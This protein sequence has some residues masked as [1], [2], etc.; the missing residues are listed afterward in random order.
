MMIGPFA[1]GT[2]DAANDTTRR[3]F[4]KPPF[5]S[6]VTQIGS[7]EFN[8]QGAYFETADLVECPLGVALLRKPPR[9]L[10]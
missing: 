4:D 2:G 6:L 1:R 10:S 3:E 7:I 9:R 5:S 8:Q